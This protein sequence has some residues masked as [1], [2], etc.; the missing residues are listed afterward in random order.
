MSGHALGTDRR[1][2][3]PWTTSTRRRSREGTESQQGLAI[4]TAATRNHG[5][6]VGVV[7]ISDFLT[8]PDRPCRAD[9]DHAAFDVDVRVGPARMVDVPGLVAAHAGVDDAAV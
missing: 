2:I 8:S 3:A 5:V 1:N 9:P 6:A 4:R 7:V